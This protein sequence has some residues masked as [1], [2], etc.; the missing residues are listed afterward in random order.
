M[1][2]S[3]W[4]CWAWKDEDNNVRYIGYG[5]YDQGHPAAIKWRS[6]YT[7]DSPLHLWLQEH[8]QEPIR[9]VCGAAVMNRKMALA[10]AVVYRSRYKNTILQSRGLMT[11]RGGGHSREVIYCPMGDILSLE[12]YSSVRMASREIGLA[13]SNVTRNCQ[14]PRNHEW[15]YVNTKELG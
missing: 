1:N 2:P 12:I 11:Y 13:P 15:H 10:L 4:A 7:D 3:K 6:R 5:P 14:N 8:P 9:E